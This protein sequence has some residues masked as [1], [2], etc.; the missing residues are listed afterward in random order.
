MQGESPVPLG[1]RRVHEQLS[2]QGKSKQNENVSRCEQI[3]MFASFMMLPTE[4]VRRQ[5]AS[6]DERGRDMETILIVFLVVFLL[7]GGLGILSLA[8]LTWVAERDIFG[9]CSLW[10]TVKS[11]DA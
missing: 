10:R 6:S 8:Q 11:K 5:P 7:G 4:E 9:G 1:K 2:H 3:S